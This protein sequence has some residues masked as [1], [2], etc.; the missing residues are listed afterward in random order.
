MIAYLCVS[1]FPTVSLPYFITFVHDMC[2]G[3]HE[4]IVCDGWHLN[5]SLLTNRCHRRSLWK[6]IIA[7][8]ITS[9]LVV[10]TGFV[11]GV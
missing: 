11:E 7:F 3:L 6:A 9:D 10:F 8:D 1:L 5:H 4:L 2:V